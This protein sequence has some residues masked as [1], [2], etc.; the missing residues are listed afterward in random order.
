M[1]AEPKPC[2]ARTSWGGLAGRL[3]Y[4]T[5]PEGMPDWLRCVHPRGHVEAG[6][7]HR[8]EWAGHV[9]EWE[10]MVGG[11]REG[12][13]RPALDAEAKRTERVVVRVRLDELRALEGAAGALGVGPWLRGLGMRAARRRK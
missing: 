2:T 3:G 4:A 6:V 11:V 7:P 1:P 12:A 9:W 10:P 5:R 13:G 8:A